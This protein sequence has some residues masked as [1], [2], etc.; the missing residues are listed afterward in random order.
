M[1]WGV[2]RC[3]FRRR[4]ALLLFRKRSDGRTDEPGRDTNKLVLINRGRPLTEKNGCIFSRGYLREFLTKYEKL[5]GQKAGQDS[6]FIPES[7]ADSTEEENKREREKT[8]VIWIKAKFDALVT[9]FRQQS[10][11]LNDTVFQVNNNSI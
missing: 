1:G 3:R 8:V 5:K 9:K 6:R 7:S 4:F 2:G 11:R 10:F